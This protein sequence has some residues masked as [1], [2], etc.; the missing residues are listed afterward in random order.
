[1]CMCSW[2]NHWILYIS[3]KTASFEQWQVSSFYCFTLFSEKFN[4][5]SLQEYRNKKN[6]SKLAREKQYL[7]VYSDRSSQ[8]VSGDIKD[9]NKLVFAKTYGKVVYDIGIAFTW[10]VD[11]KL[12]KR[13]C[14]N[15]LHLQTQI[16]QFNLL[17]IIHYK[18]Q[19]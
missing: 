7:I 10:S 4:K 3:C 11:R 1:M 13:K 12:K 16:N 9:I 15:N 18:W 19:G 6:T 17:D 8:W 14:M 5:H 2:S